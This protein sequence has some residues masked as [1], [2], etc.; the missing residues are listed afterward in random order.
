MDKAI[1]PEIIYGV[2]S[3]LSVDDILS[4]RLVNK[5]FADI[6]AAYMLPEVTFYMHQQELNRLKEISLHPVFSKHVKSLTYF[7][8]ALDSPKLTWREFMHDHKREMR[9]NS[10]LKK[11][12]LTPAQLMAEYKKYIDALAE[13]DAIFSSRYDIALLSDIL[14][15][16][17]QLK[18][19]TMSAGNTFY[20]GHYRLH[21]KKPLDDFLRNGYMT[22]IHPEG[23]RPL[24][25]LLTANAQAQCALTSLRA[26]SLHWRFFK[27]SSRQLTRMFRPLANLTSIQLT[28]SVDPADEKIRE[29]NSLR[30]CQRVLAKGAI[31]KILGSMPQL[32]SV[33]IEIIN[34][35]CDEKEKGAWLRD[36]IEPGFHWP[37]LKEL[38]LGGIASNRTELMNALVLHKDTLQKLCLRDITL[39]STSWKKLLPDI[40][41]HLCLAEACIC[42]DIY[43]QYEDE[44][45]MIDPLDH[46]MG[47]PEEG[48]QYWDL[49]VPEVGPHDMRDSIN[50]YCRQGGQRYPDELPLVRFPVFFDSPLACLG[51]NSRPT[52]SLLLSF[53]TKL[54]DFYSSNDS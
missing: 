50:M 11:L 15:R 42:G 52:P 29:G 16:F 27:R 14:P 34:L 47:P 4:F 18:V 13:Q 38:V 17:P 24:D 46:L 21:R 20:E 51:S 53:S 33:R 45:D 9:W 49:S 2:C 6:G 5:L 37:N 28:V 54:R 19:L 26:G 36:I 32:R 31:R 1:P 35:E 10:K 48:L 23:K 12:N 41:K 44:D 22:S 25:A 30:K 3:L 43:G 40:R 39:A 8:Q 7:A